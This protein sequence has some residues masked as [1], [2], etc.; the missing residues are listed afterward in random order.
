MRFLK[1]NCDGDGVIYKC[2]DPDEARITI[3]FELSFCFFELQL[4][5]GVD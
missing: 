1:E 3:V 5:I 4:T 2:L